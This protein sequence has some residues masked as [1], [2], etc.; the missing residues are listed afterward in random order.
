MKLI[1]SNESALDAI[2]SVNNDDKNDDD[3]EED[4]WNRKHIKAHSEMVVEKQLRKQRAALKKIA[5]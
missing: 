3:M 4:V 2:S 1:I 5:K